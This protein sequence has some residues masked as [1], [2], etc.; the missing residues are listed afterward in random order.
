MADILDSWGNHS[1]AG[2]Y[3]Y[4][5]SII[6]ILEGPKYASAFV[7]DLLSWYRHKIN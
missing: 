6:D 2:N 4:R 1:L 5:S 3:F 7:F